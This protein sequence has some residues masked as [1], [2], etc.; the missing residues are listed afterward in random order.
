MASNSDKIAEYM[1]SEQ[2]QKEYI[3]KTGIQNI[4]VCHCIS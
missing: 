1:D 3:I 2:Q 4:V